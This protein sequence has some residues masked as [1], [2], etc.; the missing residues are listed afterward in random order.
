MTSTDVRSVLSTTHAL[1]VLQ[2]DDEDENSECQVIH[3]SLGE[4]YHPSS[5]KRLRQGFTVVST[6]SDVL[7]VDINALS[8]R[9]PM[10]ELVV[11]KTPR[12]A[13]KEASDAKTRIK[14]SQCPAMF[15]A[16]QRHGDTKMY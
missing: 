6:S 9:T 3:R 5:R 11:Q 12:T 2:I 8:S 13:V 15:L 16:G 1:C 7:C 4:F 10:C 14:A